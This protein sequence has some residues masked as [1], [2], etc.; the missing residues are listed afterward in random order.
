MTPQELLAKAKAKADQYAT[1][2]WFSKVKETTAEVYLYD[3]IGADMWG[4]GISAKDF[5]LALKDAAGCDHLKVR[6]N[7]PG[8]DVFDG[9]AIY[10]LIRNFKGKKTVC[11]DGL[12]ASAAS[13]VAMAG[14]QIEIAANATMMIHE[15]WGMAVG[16]ASDMRETADLL[17]KVTKDNVLAT[18]KRT[19]Q[20]DA[21]LAAWM[22]AETWMNAEECV[23]RGFADSISNDVQNSAGLAPRA[24]T[25]A[26]RVPVVASIQASVSA[27]PRKDT[28]MN[29]LETLRNARASALADIEAIKA[30]QAA[31]HRVEFTTEETEQMNGLFAK[32]DGLNAQIDM[33]EKS[34]KLAAAGSQPQARL[35]ATD[36][37]TGTQ[38]STRPSI[39]GGTSVSAQFGNQGFTRG[40]SEFLNAVKM[41]SYGKTD[42]RL[43]N[44]VTTYGGEQ[45]G[46]DGGFAVPPDFA[47]S[48]TQVVIGEDSLVGKFNP[49]MT[50]GNQ[51]VLPTDET[52]P[53]GTTG[54]YAEWLNEAS[55][56][57]DRKPALNQ[58]TV[59][60]QKVGAMVQL[61]DE[62]AA[63]GPA[64]QSHVLRKVGDAITSK[65]NEAIVFG[66]GVAKPL[67][68]N[69]APG[70]V[71]QAKSGAS[72]AAV[73]L[74]SMLSRMVPQS[75]NN[76]FWLVHS[77]VL[78]KV[79]TLT[80]GQMP[81]FVSDFRQSPYGTI[82]GRPVFVTEYC[83]DYNTLGDIVLVSPDGYVL[84]V[85]AGGVQTAAS[86]HFA[87]NQDIQSFRA[88]MRVGGQPLAKAA[89][90]RKNG[91]TTLSHIVNLQVRS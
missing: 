90:S 72:L 73:D 62:L 60:C 2:R 34:E 38:S 37:F 88:I 63:D 56:M 59:T 4:A 46:S 43:L 7:S 49:I 54:I 64:I 71:T 85:K 77:S 40:F 12:A 81:I 15:A 65:V 14:D 1:R 58:L 3:A 79:W 24:A 13:M 20:T 67:G 70:L 89:I 10:N 51:L 84:A 52:T 80:L 27:T 23:Q 17:D 42:A 75:V 86:I 26:G 82:L 76:C 66:N 48:I 44:A 19:G 47:T 5:A 61:S 39:T 91:S 31:A 68:L 16:T 33:H 8:G 83:S 22:E 87:F 21:Q 25:P 74:A 45:T 41:S 78:P 11:I 32:I 55:A 18:Y 57:T 35:V 36:S 50:S 30:A 29:P 69:N 28:K 6:I 53:Y 9:V